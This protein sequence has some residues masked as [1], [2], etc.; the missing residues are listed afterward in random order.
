MEGLAYD[1]GMEYPVSLIRGEACLSPLLDRVMEMIGEAGDATE[2]KH[3]SGLRWALLVQ[4]SVAS[5]DSWTNFRKS[6]EELGKVHPPIPDLLTVARFCGPS[7][8]RPGPVTV[9]RDWRGR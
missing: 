1:V 6:E 5:W 2:G 8:R 3:Q 9:P 4:L 7:S